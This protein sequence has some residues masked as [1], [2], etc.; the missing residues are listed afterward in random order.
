MKR[1]RI[2]R[3]NYIEYKGVKYH[4]R[5]DRE[6]YNI[7]INMMRE[8]PRGRVLDLAAGS[9]FTSVQLAELGFNVTAYD[10]NIDQFVPND[11]P[12][13]KSDLNKPIPEPD[14]SLTGVLALEIIEHVENPK[15]FL[16]EIGRLVCS[17]GALVLST[18]NIVSIASK[19]RFVFREEMELFFDDSSRVRDPF[20]SEAS[21]HITPLL[22]WL[23]RTFLSDAGF[24]MDD[25][26]YTPRWGLKNKHLGRS[27]LLRA[28][29]RA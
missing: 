6:A 19:L 26:D 14:G 18:P 29:K 24:A 20:C 10:I 27:L 15:F 4:E 9:G 2:V 25:M 22:P 8:V 13:F 11:I 7:A 21:G 3:K 1:E 5:A 12:I 28:T 16:R 17:G 23:L